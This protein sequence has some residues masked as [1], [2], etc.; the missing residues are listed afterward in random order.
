VLSA[1]FKNGPLPIGIEVDDRC[2]RIVQL[3]RHA[4]GLSLIDAAKIDRPAGGAPPGALDDKPQAVIPGLE[5]RIDRGGFV[6]QRCVLSA[7]DGVIHVR[8]I[9]QP[10][11]TDEETDRAVSLEAADR[12]GFEQH[13][14]IRVD[15]LRAGEVRKGEAQRDEVIL[16]GGRCDDLAPFADAVIDAG[17]RPV[18]IEPSFV[19]IARAY[20]RTGRRPSDT[21]MVRLILEIGR[22]KTGLVITRGADVAFYKSLS[23]GGRQLDQAAA[24]R[25]GLEPEVVADLRRKRMRPTR[26]SSDAGSDPKTDRALFDAA[27]P[28]LE[29]LAGEAAMCLRYFSVTFSGN[30]PEFALASGGEAPEPGL[31]DV[32]SSALSLP[33][34]VGSPFDGVEAS[35][36]RPEIMGE[37]LAPEW[38]AAVGLSLRGCTVRDDV[39]PASEPAP[40]SE[41]VEEEAAEDD[42]TERVAA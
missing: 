10:R 39:E 27:R 18:G 13:E 26:R 4:E 24:E 16:V 21:D 14:D 15:W 7:P 40:M 6:G 20:A 17:L 37:L 42:S 2:A 9:R 25:L 19:A 30:R 36:R 34:R 41:E 32:L 33:V 28:L 8:S 12:L 29:Q 35:A 3:R 5:E 11:M 1:L 38:A 22:E 23:F 31:A